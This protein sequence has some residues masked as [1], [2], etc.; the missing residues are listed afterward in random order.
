MQNAY[1]ACS[2]PSGIA[3]EIHYNLDYKVIQYCDDTNWIAVGKSIQNGKDK[4]L[5][6]YWKF[7]ETSGSTALDSSGNNN[8]G[9]L[10]NM[11]AGAHVAGLIGN[12]LEFDGIDDFVNIANSTGFDFD[13]GNG[14]FTISMWIRPSSF[15]NE[16]PSSARPWEA[17]Y[18]NASPS[19][20][21]LQINNAAD[22]DTN[23]TY[24]GYDSTGVYNSTSSASDVIQLNMWTH[25][26]IV[27][28]R[29]NH[30]ART[31]INGL[32]SGATID[33]S[34]WAG[35]ISCSPVTLT[36]S[37]GGYNTSF[38][39]QGRIDEVRFYNT[40]ISSV[41]IQ[42]LYEQGLAFGLVAYWK[43]D[44]TSGTTIYDV[45]GSNNGTWLG[46]ADVNPI[47][48][49]I[50][51]AQQFNTLYDERISVGSSASINNIS[52][53]V[54]VAGWINTYDLTNSYSYIFSNDRDCCGVYK[55]YDL[56]IQTTGPRFQVW[57]IDST[58]HMAFAGAVPK[59]QWNHFAGTYDGTQLQIYKNGVLAGT[60]IYNGSI[61]TPA[62]FA[63]V[64][65][66][67]ASHT[68][69][70]LTGALDDI[71]IYNRVLSPAEMR[72][73]ARSCSNPAEPEGT[74]RFNSDTYVLMFC[75]G[76]EWIAMGPQGNGGTG[77]T[78]PTGRAGE[79]RY[80]TDL[81]KLV[82]CEGDQWIAM[83][84]I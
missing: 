57:G 83:G 28:D 81:N 82:Y 5:I 84:K 6:G 50:D 62:S 51:G 58:N 39:F 24:G 13:S 52:T 3:G 80:N 65:G 35:T 9:S 12:A 75:N 73:L 20:Q 48:G 61:D 2:N 32:Q 76:Q 23:S 55:G 26:A 54:T 45:A 14:S 34:S 44:E 68:G 21:F 78:G 67:L 29:N 19:Y 16:T 22:S 69:L 42:K 30:Q 43:L 72:I 46:S 66:G 4:N 41:N 33:T 49:V 18:C 25:I 71:R 47:T 36:H 15:S 11:G 31:Y 60:T 64:I 7:D 74:I 40:A 56:R 79:I 59:N 37:I 38:S 63:G 70:T 10:I 1:A 8:T 77:C 53:N 27:I 17:A